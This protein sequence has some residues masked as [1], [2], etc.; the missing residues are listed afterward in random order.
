MAKLRQLWQEETVGLHLRLLVAR[1]LLAP[2]PPHVG[3]RVRPLVLRA[4]GFRIGRGTVMWGTPIITGSGDIYRRLAVG[5]ECW[6]N[7]GVLINLG[8]EVSIGDRVGLGHQVMILTETHP[9]GS[10]ERRAGPVLARPVRIG[11]G[12]WLGTRAL[13]LP[14]VEIGAGAVVA[15]GAV[16]TKDV[17]P[18]VLV[19]GVPARVLRELEAEHATRST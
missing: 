10:P 14:G 6:F 8:A 4:A 7:V 3:S 19:G 11:D 2:L 17:P 16:V 15:A 12:A 9:I 5:Q 13:I 18:N 1:A